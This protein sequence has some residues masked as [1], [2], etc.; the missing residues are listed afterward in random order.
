MANIAITK[1]IEEPIQNA[2]QVTDGISTGYTG[3]SGFAQFRWPGTLTVDLGSSATVYCIRFLLWD[4]LGQ[5]GRQ[6]DSRIYKYR[7]LTSLDH[8]TWNVLFDTGDTGSN[9]WQV[10]AFPEGTE[11][12]YVRIHGLFNSANEAFH[13]VEIEVYDDKNP[14][15]LTAECRLEKTISNP[16]EQAETG[17]AFPLEDK[18]RGIIDQI[19]QLVEDNKAILNPDPFRRLIAQLRTQVTDI[20]NIEKAMNS[21]RREIMDPVKAELESSGRFSVWGFVVGIIGGL[22]ACVSL[23]VTLWPAIIKFF[24]H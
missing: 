4:K 18:V 10:F 15:A 23:I 14:P 16:R 6:R 11:V 5:K 13:V 9:G 7:L 17:D 22:L 20:T 3:M 19:D 8:Q 2:A 1:R 24:Q 12:R 21:I